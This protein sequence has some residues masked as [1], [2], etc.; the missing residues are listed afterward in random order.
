MKEIDHFR[1]SSLL[2]CGFCMYNAFFAVPLWV[3]YGF[4]LFL[5][6]SFSSSQP[7]FVSYRN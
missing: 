7:I 2:W 3:L 1:L 6:K 5:C 4:F